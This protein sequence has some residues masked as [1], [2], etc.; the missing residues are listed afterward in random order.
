MVDPEREKDDLTKVEIRH[1]R[2]A[3]DSLNPIEMLAQGRGSVISNKRAQHC[4][5][6]LPTQIEQALCTIKLRY[7]NLT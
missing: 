5:I 2:I 6:P 4:C 3:I 1:M 7:T